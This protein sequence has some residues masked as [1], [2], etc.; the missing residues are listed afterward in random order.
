MSAPIIKYSFNDSN[1]GTDSSTSG[2]NATSTNVTLVT[3]PERGPVASFD[4]STSG[5]LLSSGFVPS[6]LSGNSNRY[7]MM[8]V[9]PIGTNNRVTIFDS[10]AFAGYKRFATFIHGTRWR[11]HIGY[12][13]YQFKQWGRVRIGNMVSCC[14][15][16]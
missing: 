13:I 1:F 14:L 8:W 2:L 5:V 12:S 10:G 16:I 9:K 11:V 7:F 4:G 6:A 15:Y 3:D